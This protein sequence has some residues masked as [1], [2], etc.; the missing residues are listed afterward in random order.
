MF[1]SNE[2]VAYTWDSQ[3]RCCGVRIERRGERCTVAGHWRGAKVGAQPLATVLESSLAHLKIRSE[4]TVLIGGD[5]RKAFCVDMRMPKMS[6]ELLHSAVGF[7][8]AKFSPLATEDLKWGYRVLSKSGMDALHVRVGFFP[9][10]DHDHWLEAASALPSGVDMIIPAGAT[11]DPQFAEQDVGFV[12]EEGESAYILHRKESGEREV[13]IAADADRDDV[14]GLGKTPLAAPNL[15]PGRLLE[16]N[17]AEQRSF[18]PAVLLG[19]YGVSS[20]CPADARTWLSVP[21]SMK[22]PRNRTQKTVS[23]TLAVYL[24][25]LGLAFLGGW[26]MMKNRDLAFVNEKRVALEEEVRRLTPEV[27]PTHEVDLNEEMRQELEEVRASFLPMGVGLSAITGRTAHELWGHSFQWN[28]GEIKVELIADADMMDKIG[29]LE[30]T[31]V[32]ADFNVDIARQK[33]QFRY[34][35]NCRLMRDSE[36]GEAGVDVNSITFLK[37]SVPDDVVPDDIPDSDGEEL[38]SGLPPGISPP[39][40]KEM[41]RPPT[42]RS[43]PA[44]SNGASRLLPPPPPPPPVLPGGN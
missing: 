37:T 32:L 4:T 23:L 9:A 33:G 38:D 28:T 27:K 24:L 15:M 44:S 40:L 13:Q 8:L 18:A 2:C 34:T 26:L 31:R 12:D 6:P 36:M 39:S 43:M 20:S 41:N 17:A 35:V 25:G 21:K 11:L 30:R 3:G 5:F 10:S 14:F 29:F 16:L 42:T 19:M 1:R 22:P 7:E